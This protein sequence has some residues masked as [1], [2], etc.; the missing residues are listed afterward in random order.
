M[1]YPGKASSSQAVFTPAAAAHGA[2]DVIGAATEFK[3]LAQTNGAGIQI[4]SA[5][6]LVA[7]GTLVTTVWRVHLYNVT[8][9]S[10]IADNGLFDIA[11]GDRASYLGYIDIAQLVD[12]GSTLYVQS[13]NLN[14]AI[15]LAG[16]S[17][18]GYLVATSGITT[19]AVAHTVTLHTVS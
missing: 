6:L 15:R 18:W 17:A 16:R 11:A 4:V 9:P 12:I 8:P 5:S 3:G 19:E 7:T 1:P 14:K 10:A 13:D 2:V